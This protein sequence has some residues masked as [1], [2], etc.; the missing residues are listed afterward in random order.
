[1]NIYL[2]EIILRFVVSILFL[3]SFFYL[4]IFEVI[5][6]FYYVIYSIISAL[7]RV[8]YRVR[9]TRWVFFT[10]AGTGMG[11]FA[12]TNN[13]RGYGYGIELPDGFLPVAIPSPIPQARSAAG[14]AEW[15]GS[16]TARRG[17]QHR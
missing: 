16:S 12:G 14:W 11:I 7:K 8:L 10:R 3:L 2:H 9:V 4:I 5:C 13:F 15:A 1:M 17:E 6:G